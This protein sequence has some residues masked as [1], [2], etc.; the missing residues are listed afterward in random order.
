MCACLFFRFEIQF[1]GIVVELILSPY[2]TQ[3][4]F[5]N[6]F[7][8]FRS[9]SFELYSYS[10]TNVC[11]K[12]QLGNNSN[13]KYI[14]NILCFSICFSSFYFYLFGC[15]DSFSFMLVILCWIFISTNFWRTQ[16]KVN[17]NISENANTITIT[18]KR[19]IFV[20]L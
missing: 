16:A 10:Y 11:H 5:E 19:K 12:N 15:C 8:T 4:W 6:L 2:E 20:P 3:Q 1:V 9:C 14:E 18:I 17:W 13:N 7:Q